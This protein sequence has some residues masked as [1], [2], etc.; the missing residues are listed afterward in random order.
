M[1]FDECAKRLA[2]HGYELIRSSSEGVTMTNGI[3]KV[4]FYNTKT[5]YGRGTDFVQRMYTYMGL[6]GEWDDYLAQ[7]EDN[8]II[9]GCPQVSIDEQVRILTGSPTEIVKKFRDLYLE[10]VL[11]NVLV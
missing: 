7:D 5:S 2:D 9:P 6:S 3:V 11:D 1:K 8:T 10:S 4:T